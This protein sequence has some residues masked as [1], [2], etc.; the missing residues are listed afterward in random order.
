[1]IMKALLLLFVFCSAS[2]TVYSQYPAC[3]NHSPYTPG[4]QLT[5]SYNSEGIGYSDLQRLT[6]TDSNLRKLSFYESQALN[7]ISMDFQCKMLQTVVANTAGTTIIAIEI[8]NPKFTDS[9]SSIFLDYN[10]M[11]RQLEKP[12]FITVSPQGA[13]TSIH[14]DAAISYTTFNFI[15]GM[16]CHLQFVCTSA[17]AK[18]WHTTEDNGTG[19]YKASYTTT[20]Q[21]ATSTQYRKT[22]TGYTRINNAR[23]NEQIRTDGFTQYTFSTSGIAK[24]IYVS[25]VSVTTFGNDTI[26]ISGAKVTMTQQS[27]YPVT[28][29]QLAALRT[30]CTQPGYAKAAT[31]GTVLTEEEINRK[32]DI[33]TLAAENLHSLATRLYGPTLDSEAERSLSFKYEALIKL[34]PDSCSALVTMLAKEPLG[35]QVFNILAGALAAAQTSYGTNAIVALIQLRMAEPRTVESLLPIL[36]LTKAPTAKAISLAKA[37]IANATASHRTREEAQLCLAA[38]AR[39]IKRTNAQLSVST[40]R[41]V[42][43]SVQVLPDTLQQVLMLGSTGARRALPILK[44]YYQGS[45]VSRSIQAHAVGAMKYIEGNDVTTLLQGIKEGRDTVLA[46]AA[47]AAL[48]L[49]EKAMGSGQ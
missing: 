32:T 11:G 30:M 18:E 20:S 12:F 15:R 5:Y 8:T 4:T 14:I 16:L 22:N 28:G 47:A 17:N 3:Y 38:M 46:T 34:H 37:L 24:S 36:T 2:A 35:T 1:M 41:Y 33:K 42:I 40:T 43:D 25:Q 7:T 31:T 13:I 27:V 19:T 29:N 48:V 23:K 44:G 10:A 6:L 21:N 9:G 26:S 49:R 45:N 39:H